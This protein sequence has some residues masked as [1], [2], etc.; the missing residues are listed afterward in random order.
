MVVNGRRLIGQAFEVIEVRFRHPVSDWAPDSA[1][2][3]E[4][5]LA[6]PLRFE[7]ED[8]ALVVSEATLALPMP[9]ADPAMFEFFDR[10]AA[11]RMAEHPPP[12]VGV[13]EDA[14]RVIEAALPEGVPELASLASGSAAAR[15]P[16]SGAW[17]STG[18][19]CAP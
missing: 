7:A 14:R 4:A 17:P 10:E 19:R 12:S 9:S 13:L 11:R 5:L 3:L 15:G 18:R 16:C 2:R 8:N 6:A 1:A